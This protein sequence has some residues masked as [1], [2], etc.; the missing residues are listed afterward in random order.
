[1]RDLIHS[2]WITARPGRTFCR[3]ARGRLVRVTSMSRVS[4]RTWNSLYSRMAPALPLAMS[5]NAWATRMGRSQEVWRVGGK[6]ARW[7]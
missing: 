7:A 6:G 4:W 3:S 5:A 1:L 2:P